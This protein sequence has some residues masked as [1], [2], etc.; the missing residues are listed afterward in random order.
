[1]EQQNHSS[2]SDHGSGADV[3]DAPAP[4]VFANHN[5]G[6]RALIIDTRAVMGTEIARSLGRRGYA[7][8]VFAEAGSP[9]FYSRYCARRVDASRWA[10][11]ESFL[12]LLEATVRSAD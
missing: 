11:G 8:D 6:R 9:A 4:F 1:M 3:I 10:S 12:R 2:N 5:G 7:V